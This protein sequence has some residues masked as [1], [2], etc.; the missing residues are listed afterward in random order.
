MPSGGTGLGLAIVREIARAHGGE[1]ELA[2]SPL[3]GLRAEVTLPTPGSE[4]RIAQRQAGEP[5]S[6]ATR[7][8]PPRLVTSSRSRPG[9]TKTGLAGW[10]R[11]HAVGV[12]G[13]DLGG[14]AGRDAVDAVGA[15]AADEHRAVDGQR[16]AVGL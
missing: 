6:A 3:G 12:L 8:Q 15:V 4:R 7:F 14:A 1:I 2:T 5:G 9:P 11:I 13:P 10:F 16:D